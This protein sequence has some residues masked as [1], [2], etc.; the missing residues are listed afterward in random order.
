MRSLA[1]WVVSE[2]GTV[3]ATTGLYRYRGDKQGEVNL[4]W[5]CVAPEMR[6]AGLGR[7]VLEWTM[8]R[9]QIEGAKTLKLYTSNSSNEAAA[10]KLYESV[11][12]TVVREEPHGEYIYM[13][14]EK[15]F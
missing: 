9:A 5:F 14:R 6:G 15:K 8:M 13:Y 2:N 1:Y 4:G 7:K 11:G 12:L 10:Q 3:V